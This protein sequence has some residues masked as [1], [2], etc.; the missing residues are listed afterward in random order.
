MQQS[1][2]V[3]RFLEEKR[4]VRIMYCHYPSV[5]KICSV[6]C[7]VSLTKVIAIPF[8]DPVSQSSG[9]CNLFLFVGDRGD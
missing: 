6:C 4:R 3:L 7:N 1:F 5:V 9:F 8:C 2:N